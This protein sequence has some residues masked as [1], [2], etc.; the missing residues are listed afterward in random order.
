MEPCAEGGQGGGILKNFYL[1]YNY[2]KL[3]KTIM[4]KATSKN[5][6]HYNKNLQARANKLRK[7]MT[8]GEA[9]L[10]KYVLKNRSMKGYPFRRQRPVLNYIADFMCTDLLLIIGVDGITHFEEKALIKDKKREAALIKVGFTVLR[11]S[12]WEVLHRIADVA[13]LIGEWTE[14]NAILP[15]PT[16]QGKRTSDT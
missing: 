8:K 14:E 10:W 2:L 6:Y 5:N 16:P 13:V 4:Q 12:N 3:L 1:S 9:C 7:N 15:P 11:F